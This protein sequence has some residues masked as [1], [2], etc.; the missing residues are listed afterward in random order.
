MSEPIK[1]EHCSSINLIA[2][3]QPRIL[4]LDIYVYCKDCGM[5]SHISTVDEN[6]K[7]KMIEKYRKIEIEETEQ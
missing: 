4:V 3:I 6:E 1:C 2:E 7:S 5:A